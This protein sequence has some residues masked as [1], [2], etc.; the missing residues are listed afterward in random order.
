MDRLAGALGRAVMGSRGL[1]TAIPS[2]ATKHKGIKADIEGDVEVAGSMVH[3]L[4]RLSLVDFADRGGVARL[5][6]AV[7]L[8]AAVVAADTAAVEPLYSTL[9][10]ETL[11]LRPDAAEAPGCR[12]ELMATAAVTEEDYYL[13]PTGNVPLSVTNTY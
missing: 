9:E 5:G 12:A 13:A 3:T 2:T 8:A 6:E 11:A 7:R 4:E 10:Q 1:H